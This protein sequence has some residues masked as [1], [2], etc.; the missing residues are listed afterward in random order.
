MSGVEPD[1]VA[2]VSAGQGDVWSG[3]YYLTHPWLSSC[4]LCGVKP[5]RNEDGSSCGRG[6]ARWREWYAASS[7]GA[8]GRFVIMTWDHCHAHNIVRGTLCDK[9]NIE[10][11][12]DRQTHHWGERFTRWR[13]RCL[14]CVEAE[15][16]NA[17][18]AEAK[19][20]AR[21]RRVEPRRPRVRKPAPRRARVVLPSPDARI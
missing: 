16:A 20:N 1:A 17:K 6:S 8:P 12:T 5:T 9:C 10:E 15:L 21:T 19:T 11:E 2:L 7:K 4:E 3:S 13:A 18:R 14:L